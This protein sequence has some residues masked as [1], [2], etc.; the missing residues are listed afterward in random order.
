VS[1]P[2]VLGRTLTD[3]E[4]TALIGLPPTPYSIKRD[5]P[6]FPKAVAAI[7]DP[8]VELDDLVAL[9]APAD[10]Y[11]RALIDSEAVA[12]VGGMLTFYG[13]PV[14]SHLADRLGDAFQLGLS[15]DAWENLARNI[16]AN[17]DTWVRTDLVDWLE[18]SAM[19]Q[20][21]DGCFLAWKYVDQNFLSLHADTDGTRYDHTPGNIVEMDRSRCDTNRGNACSTGLHFCSLGYL[22]ATG[23][24]GR[25]RIVLVKVD[26][27]DVTSIPREA[28]L[29]KGRCCRYEVIAEVT[30]PAARQK[31]F[32]A[33][34]DGIEQPKA[35]AKKAKAKPAKAKAEAPKAK[36]KKAKTGP[37]TIKSS[38]AGELTKD[39]FDALVKRHGS[40]AKLA[41]HLGVSSG[42]VTA[43]K[44]TL[45]GGGK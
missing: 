18:L 15:V 1:N 32:T 36:A 8:A 37:V 42:T 24:G 2:N 11:E 31:T 33:V 5:H 25:Y 35:A 16:Y 14:Q 38:V 23:D 29:Q 19:P 41:K 22:P 21:P 6:R 17:P 26:P 3:S 43:W 28:S 44:R 20:T 27:R 30:D 12:V 13:E 4:L 45:N 40:Q 10:A 7:E 39:R 9:F 34:D